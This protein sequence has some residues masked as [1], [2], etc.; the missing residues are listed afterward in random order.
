MWAPGGIWVRNLICPECGQICHPK[1]DAKSALISWSM[2]ILFV[3]ATLYVFR[4][5][6]FMKYIYNNALLIYILLVWLFMLMPFFVGFRR[7]FKLVKAKNERKSFR[8]LSW[9][10]ILLFAVVFGVYT[11]DWTNIIIGFVVF[12]VVHTIFS[13]VGSVGRTKRQNRNQK[14]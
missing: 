10:F 5:T 9:F 14:V 6:A 13:Y 11:Q 4:T 12:G 1:I 2:T 7:G 3:G 8:W